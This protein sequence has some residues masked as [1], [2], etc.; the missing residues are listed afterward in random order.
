MKT[1]R[2]VGIV[3]LC[4][5]LLLASTSCST[6]DKSPPSE[7]TN[8]TCTS[9]CSDNT[10]TFT[11]EAASDE[12]SGIDSY[13]FR[14]EDE[15]WYE[16]WRI[17]GDST[18]FTCET[19][20]SDG[21]HTFEVKAVDKAGNE[22]DAASHSFIVCTRIHCDTTQPSISS[23]SASVTS[24]S[25]VTITWT[26]GEPTLYQV[27][28]GITTAYGLSTLEPFLQ[29]SYVVSHSVN[30]TGLTANTTYHYRVRS[31]DMCGNEAVSAD[32]SLV[33]LPS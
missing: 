17:I 22:G 25:S 19:P 8:L 30:L 33:T 32:Y 14:I 10:P 13:V 18:A 21:S 24:A 28:Y 9:T 20:I 29:S 11:W 27:V 23:V 5:A 16:Y 7:P 6:G 15:S 2:V 31:I 4:L 1:I 3:L 12:G 26:T